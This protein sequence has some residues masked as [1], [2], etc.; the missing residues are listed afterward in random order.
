MISLTE[1][2]IDPQ[3]RILLPRQWRAKHGTSVII[4]EIDDELRVVP[5]KR[6]KLSELKEIEVDVKSNFQ[7]WHLVKKELTRRH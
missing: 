1:K 5:K 2:T 3:G 4:F 7:D 6:K